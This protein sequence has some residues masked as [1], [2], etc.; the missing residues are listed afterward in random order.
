M[1]AEACPADPPPSSYAQAA[2]DWVRTRDGGSSPSSVT[3]VFESPLAAQPFDSP[4]PTPSPTPMADWPYVVLDSNY[5]YFSELSSCYVAVTILN[6]E[7]GKIDKLLVDV[8]SYE[9]HLA[10][11]ID[12]LRIQANLTHPAQVDLELKARLNS[13]KPGETIPVIVWLRTPH[14]KDLGTRQHAAYMEL[15]EMFPEAKAALEEFGNP[16]SVQDEELLGVIRTE[17]ELL[18]RE[19]VDNGA[20]L[21][22]TDLLTKQHIVF[23]SMSPMPAIALDASPEIIEMLQTS[24]RIERI[25]RAEEKEQVALADAG[26]THGISGLATQGLT[27]EGRM[28]GILEAGNVQWSNQ[29]L[30]VYPERL[31]SP[32]GEREHTTNVAACAASFYPSAPGAAPH[33]QIV[34]AG[35]SGEPLATILGLQWLSGSP[36]W[37][38]TVNYSATYCF[39]TYVEFVTRAFDYWSRANNTLITAAAGNGEDYGFEEDYVCS[40]ANGYNVV[41]VGSFDNKNTPPWDDDVVS[42]FSSWRDP[43]SSYNDF[44]KPDVVAVGERLKLWG[45]N[46]FLYSEKQGTSLAAPQVAGLAS[47]LTN[48]NER[49]RHN[50]DAVK[51]ILMASAMHNLDGPNTLGGPM[52]TRDGAGGIDGSWAITA[53]RTSPKLSTGCKSSCWRAGST[54]GL[55]PGETISYQFWA[56]GGQR[57]RA[58]LVWWATADSEPYASEILDNDLDLRIKVRVWPLYTPETTSASHSNNVELVDFVA[59]TTD[60]YTLEVTKADRTRLDAPVTSY[61][62]AIVSTR[63]TFLPLAIN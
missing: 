37:I 5:A 1:A 42:S 58:A 28:I 51:A 63:Q 57:V 18:M 48:V 61:G 23:R 32:N 56:I 38:D 27:G 29:Y 25:Y 22:V 46:N 35:T 20:M 47:L 4:L 33:A 14:G 50:P 59:P 44:E 8:T 10:G 7:S 12:E 24:R 16:F 26:Q 54:A 34:S 21:E 9:V 11:D 30:D 45:W 41:A 17:Y 49:L 52:D 19:S 43:L 13:L 2:I 40:P 60:W 6:Q 3:P 15:A 36:L 55:A 39:G 62:V 31:A 53:A